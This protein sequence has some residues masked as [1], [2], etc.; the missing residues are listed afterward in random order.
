MEQPYI[1][2]LHILIC[3]YQVVKGTE[4]RIAIMAQILH[5]PKS[6]FQYFLLAYNMHNS[7]DYIPSIKKNRISGFN[8]MSSF[9]KKKKTQNIGLPF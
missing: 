3:G 6:L 7:L 2:E 1:K 5:Q 4:E 8:S 9:F